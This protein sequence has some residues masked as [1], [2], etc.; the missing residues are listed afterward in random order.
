MKRFITIIMFAVLLGGMARVEAQRPAYDTIGPRVSEYMY[1]N[2]PTD[3]VLP[4]CSLL[5]DKICRV[6]MEWLY[7]YRPSLYN[8]IHSLYLGEYQSELIGSWISGREIMVNPDEPV[9]VI[10]V[11]AVVVLDSD[12]HIQPPGDPYIYSMDPP[13]RDLFIADTTI[14]GRVD[15]YLQLY[16]LYDT[17][18]QLESEG[19]WRY[20]DTHRYIRLT[21]SGGDSI[22][23]V[24]EEY[25][26]KPTVFDTNFVVAGTCY[27]N[28]RNLIGFYQTSLR[29]RTFC[30]NQ[31]Q[32]IRTVYPTLQVA[33][34]TNLPMD[35]WWYKNDSLGGWFRCSSEYTHFDTIYHSSI[36]SHYDHSRFPLIFPILDTNYVLCT[37]V[38]SV[39]VAA[40]DTADVGVT[41]MWDAGAHQTE[42]EVAYG[43]S[44]DA[45]TDYTH[46]TATAPTVT[47]SGLV[48]ETQYSVIVRGDCGHDNL[49]PWSE[50]YTFNAPPE[51]DTTGTGEGGEGGEG[52][53]TTAVVPTTNLARFTQVLPN[54][55]EDAVY[56]ISSYTLRHIDVYDLRGR[57]VLDQDAEGV[58]GTFDVSDWPK[59]VYVVALRTPQG[60]ATKRL[61]VQ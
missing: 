36:L 56:V 22:C 17:V 40:Y 7:R 4:S 8:Y 9:R 48:P 37:E 54:P 39:R 13:S 25:F 47:L 3:T 27:N 46:V 32:H 11:A 29:T 34:S 53:D 49:G 41:L 24:Y 5:E 28:D 30:Y 45:W 42:W 33:P 14:S 21:L 23:N 2:W 31:W 52:G 1:S 57:K 50:L 20:E 51:A 55:A 59:G 61:V 60:L 6:S 16:N 44:T 10:G 15:E 26:N 19:V 12:Y 18:P 58:T 43:L 35:T 38:S